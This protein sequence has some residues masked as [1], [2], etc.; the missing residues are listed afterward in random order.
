M[1]LVAYGHRCVNGL[2]NAGA[3]SPFGNREGVTSVLS[4][5]SRLS[6][7]NVS[8]SKRGLASPLG[9]GLAHESRNMSRTEWEL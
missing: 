9:V 5:G 3:T 7:R 1:M 4:H 2:V 6:S 8:A